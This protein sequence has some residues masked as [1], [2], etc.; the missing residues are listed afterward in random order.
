MREIVEEILKEEEQARQRVEKA[1]KDAENIILAARKDTNDFLDKAALELAELVRQ[2]KEEAEKNFLR[3]KEIALAR[4]REESVTLRKEK[5]K[6]L[7]AIS[8]RVFSRL[9]DIKG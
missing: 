6:T 2:R 9:I 8:H 3:E 7:T 4:T 1:R 5:E